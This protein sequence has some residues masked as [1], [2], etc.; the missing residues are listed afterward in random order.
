MK[1]ETRQKVFVVLVVGVLIMYYAFYRTPRK[2]TNEVV[3]QMNA[4]DLI[5]KEVKS[6]AEKIKVTR[7]INDTRE[8]QAVEKALSSLPASDDVDALVSLANDIIRRGREDRLRDGA[9][10]SGRPLGT[11]RP[12][13]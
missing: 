10:V 6:S 13:N 12:D 4:T 5:V 8:E 1:P 11:N 9:D 3:E 7:I 2:A